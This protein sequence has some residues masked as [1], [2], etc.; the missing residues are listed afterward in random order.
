[1]STHPRSRWRQALVLGTALSLAT[2][3]AACGGDDDPTSTDGGGGG[4]DAP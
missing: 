2:A 1:M 3:L 4:G